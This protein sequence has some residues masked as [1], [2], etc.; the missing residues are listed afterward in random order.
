MQKLI[1][2]LAATLLVVVVGCSAPAGD[3]EAVEGGEE[4]AVEETAVEESTEEMAEEGSDEEAMPEGEELDPIDAA[5]V[6]GDPAQCEAL[7][8]AWLVEACLQEQEGQ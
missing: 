6:S 5:I 1:A 8:E 7:G 2:L 4:T 3:E